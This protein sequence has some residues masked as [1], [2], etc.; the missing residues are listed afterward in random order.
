MYI[1]VWRQNK[2][3]IMKKHE[4][5]VCY[6]KQKLKL[7]VDLQ[8]RMNKK[9]SKLVSFIMCYKLLEKHKKNSIFNR[10]LF[11]RL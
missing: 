6:F 2:K 9:R 8:D 7:F 10:L 5:F 11:N 1:F 4:L 3:L